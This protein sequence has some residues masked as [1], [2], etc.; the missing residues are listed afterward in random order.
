MVT[1][2]DLER[3]AEADPRRRAGRVSHRDGL[4]PG[5]EC[6][7][8]RGRATIF[9]LK[10]RPSTSPLIVHVDSIEM[11][12]SLVTDWPERA[13]ELAARFWPGPLT[14]VLPKR[15]IV[16]DE[17]TAGLD[18]VGIRMPAHPIALAL[19]RAAGVPI[20]APS[21]NRFTRTLAHHRR[22][23]ARSFRRFASSYSTADPRTSA[24]N[25]P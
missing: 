19:I 16:P 12:Q 23:R 14:L 25:P 5:R 7:R 6:A 13:G 9:E 10:G 18:T 1:P 22:T 4:R 17:I 11:A 3:A 24:S 20:A 2:E 21:A 8:C 15:P